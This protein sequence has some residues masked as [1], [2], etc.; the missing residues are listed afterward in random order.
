[1]I[2]NVLRTLGGVDRFGIFSLL[3]FITVF[4]GVLL[5]ALVQ[6]RQHLDRMASLPI[7]EQDSESD[8]HE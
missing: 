1:M 8:S 3:L 2:Q 7:E 4:T 6:R 5:W